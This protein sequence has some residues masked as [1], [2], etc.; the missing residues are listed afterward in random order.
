MS[1]AVTIPQDGLRPYQRADFD[2]INA[3][4][5]SGVRRL[6]YQLVTGAGK[7]VVFVRLALEYVARGERVLVLVQTREQIEQALA[8]LVSAGLD[9]RHIGV[10]R[11]DDARANPDA[12]VQL[13]SV[14]TL[15]RRERE[16]LP[17][18]RLVVLDEAHH[19][20][21]AQTSALLD[22]YAASAF[23]LGVTATPMRNDGQPLGQWF[24]EL[25]VSPAT[26][27]SLIEA[28]YLSDPL[29]LTRNDGVPEINGLRR[30]R[31]DYERGELGRRVSKRN[32][33]GRIVATW[34]AHAEG[35]PT[36]AFAASIEHAQHIRNAFWRERIKVEL[37]HGGTPNRDRV[38]MLQR[39]ADG[40]TKVIVTC[41]ILSEGWDFA[42][43]RC[44]IFARPTLS[45]IIFLQQCG[46]F[47]RPGETRPIILDHA[48]N[49]LFFGHPR[50]PV[51]WSLDTALPP[52]PKRTG[53]RQ[54]ATREGVAREP[55]EV[56]GVLVDLDTMPKVDPIAIAPRQE[57]CAGREDGVCPDGK[58]PGR[59]VFRASMVRARNGRPWRC[60]RCT[61]ALPEEK[62]KRAE[63]LRE[64]WARPE[65]KAKHAEAV[66]RPEF[67]AKRAEALRES[68]AR[69]EFKAKRAAAT[70]EAM[71]RPEVKARHAAA[72]MEAMA[73]L[74][75]EERSERTRRGN[76]TRRA[77]QEVRE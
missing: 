2:H 62:A 30:V 29:I 67:K 64:S 16:R 73:R 24:D 33:I 23:V 14:Q 45:L 53:A 39:L 18:A 55:Y 5:A 47:M 25:Y 9:E 22:H 75:P 41:D 60:R 56:E 28:G 4:R 49:A 6:L 71:A 10:I 13:A 48:G 7:T 32:I 19:A 40:I 74:T 66:A 77:K 26:A 51:P 52:I 11:A 58:R 21:A 44:A 50:N 27:L 65:V 34:K 63:A 12:P 42:V 37:L 61:V 54:S 72:T 20:G 15:A 43:A 17:A 70:M 46:R 69:P 59:W 76:E 68:W 31:G 38:A 3:R 8:R 35:R 57:V 1:A 36:V